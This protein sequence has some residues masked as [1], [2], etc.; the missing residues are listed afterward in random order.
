MI[1]IIENCPDQ[2]DYIIQ[3]LFRVIIH[4]GYLLHTRWHTLYNSYISNRLQTE[5]RHW[6]GEEVANLMAVEIRDR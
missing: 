2:V 6:F 3:M 1:P 5:N 4:N